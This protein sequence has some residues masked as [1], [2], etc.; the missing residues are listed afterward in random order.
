MK[1]LGIVHYNFPGFSF[2][3]FLKFTAEAG[4]RYVELQLPDVWGKDVVN[5]EQYAERVRKEVNPLR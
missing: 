4:Y 3:W 5:P 2:Q 1:K